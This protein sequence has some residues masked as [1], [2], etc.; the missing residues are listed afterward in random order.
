[1]KKSELVGNLRGNG[2]AEI[3]PHIDRNATPPNETV[4]YTACAISNEV[5]TEGRPNPP[6][7]IMVFSFHDKLKVDRVNICRIVSSEA[8]QLVLESH[9]YRLFSAARCSPSGDAT[10]LSRSS[11]QA[12]KPE[13]SQTINN[14]CYIVNF[15][16]RGLVTTPPEDL[17]YS[18]NQ[19]SVAITCTYLRSKDI[20]GK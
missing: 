7:L 2:N 1:M 17:W 10:W 9:P 20:T 8:T 18:I 16:R 12:P 11:K 14:S 13:Q 15:S 4:M 19:I 3:D 6:P 5:H